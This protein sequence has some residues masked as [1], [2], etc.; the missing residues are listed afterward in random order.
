M[1]LPSC[2]FAAGCPYGPG[3]ARLAAH[4]PSPM[5]VTGSC[6]ETAIRTFGVL[7]FASM[8]RILQSSELRKHSLVRLYDL[9]Q[10]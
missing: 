1:I 9:L 3:D 10:T 6:R 7:P 8:I 5:S 2:R 4:L